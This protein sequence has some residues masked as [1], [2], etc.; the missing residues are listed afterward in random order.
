[1][2][3]RTSGAVPVTPDYS[4]TPRFSA[5]VYKVL[6]KVDLFH[7]YLKLTQ[8]LVRHLFQNQFLTLTT[9]NMKIT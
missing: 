7:F 8:N 5:I 2:N 1:M 6:Y 9:I 4:F 3:F